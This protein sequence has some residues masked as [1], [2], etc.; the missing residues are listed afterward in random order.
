VYCQLGRTTCK[1]V[2]RREWIPLRQVLDEIQKKTQTRP[3]YITLSGSGEPTLF[4]P[5]DGLIDGIRAFTD[6]PIA[7]LTNGS[8][9]DDAKVQQE[10]L[11][12]DLVIPSLD[13]G[14]ESVFQR[15]NRPH[16]SISFERMLEGLKTFRRMFRGQYWLEVFLL[17]DML[18][19]DPALAELRRCVEEICPDRVQLNTVARP[20][21][22][23]WAVAVSRQRLEEIAESFTP[24]AE[25]IA[26]F[27]GES[28]AGSDG[29]DRNGVFQLLMRRPCTIDDIANG[30]GMH[31]V[32]VLKIIDHLVAD[33]LVEEVHLD[34][35]RYYRITHVAASENEI[36]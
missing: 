3:D 19:G 34:G 27:H 33:K 28:L 7:V 36:L 2:E 4:T 31:R 23:E 21:T 24:K 30:L 25:V 11:G 18:G 10:L 35:V 20:P 32:E 5:L 16:A 29:L 6:I 22:E 14:N 1:T 8:L 13:A 9:L 12:A 17:G 15:V 26:D